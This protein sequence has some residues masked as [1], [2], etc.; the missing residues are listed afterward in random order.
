M[1]RPE[2]AQNPQE[3]LQASPFET[4]NDAYKKF[5]SYLQEQEESLRVVGSN[6]EEYKRYY[7]YFKRTDAFLIETKK[8]VEDLMKEGESLEDGLEKNLVDKN[9]AQD[10]LEKNKSE[11]YNFINLRNILEDKREIYF[12][13]SHY[14]ALSLYGLGKDRQDKLRALEEECDTGIEQYF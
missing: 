9:I 5:A 4:I 2:I 1:G 6:E 13:R 8:Y 14:F 3:H 11:L 12:N 10:T 7:T